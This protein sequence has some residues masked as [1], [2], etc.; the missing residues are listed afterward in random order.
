M[1]MDQC[2]TETS[3]VITYRTDAVARVYKESACDVSL[4]TPYRTAKSSKT[5]SSALFINIFLNLYL[6]K[7]VCLLC[8]KE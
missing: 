4:Q 6:G 7:N 5:P 2:Q 3:Y 8:L 1:R